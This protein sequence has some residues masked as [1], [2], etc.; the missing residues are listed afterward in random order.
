MKNE[1]LIY[2]EDIVERNEGYHE[3]IEGYILCHC[4][5]FQYKTDCSPFLK[6][7]LINLII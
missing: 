6:Y 1:Y 3:K 4:K 5:E 7:P 2:L